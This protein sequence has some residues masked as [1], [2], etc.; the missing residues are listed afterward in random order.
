MTTENN[1]MAS[2]NI[3]V[4]ILTAR[5]REQLQE[6]LTSLERQTRK[7]F[8]IVLVD[9]AP[10]GDTDEIVRQSPLQINHIKNPKPGSYAESRNL[11][12]REAKGEFVA[13]LDDDCSAD[14]AWLEHLL[15]PAESADAVG[16]MV[17]P[18]RELPFPSWWNGELNWLLGLSVPG[19]IGNQ[20]G[21]AHY[22]QTANMLVR[23]DVLLVEKFQEIGGGFDQRKSLQYTGREDVELWRR[24][25][26][27][28]RR[29]LI[30][31]RAAVYHDIPPERLEPKAMQQRAFNDGL[32]FWRREK[33]MAYC[34][35]AIMD[36]A[37]FLPEL[38]AAIHRGKSLK[39]A[40]QSLL[41]WRARQAG[42]LYG[43]AR[44]GFAPL[45]YIQIT[46]KIL[47]KGARY[48]ADLL[49][50]PSRKIY[51]ALKKPAWERQRMPIKPERVLIAACGF[52]G[53]MALLA[54]VLD[55]LRRS[56]PDAKLTLLSHPNGKILF[57]ES[58]LVD[59][60]VV[61]PSMAQLGA[62]ESGRRLDALLRNK[63]FDAVIAPYYHNAP[64][65]PVFIGAGAPV[66]TFD[67]DVGLPRR[68]WYDMARRRIR[69]NFEAHE[70]LNLARLTR[71]VGLTEKPKPYR[72][73][74]PDKAQK[75]ADELLAKAGLE[76]VRLI[77][78]H[79]GGGY[80]EKMWL[81]K[82]WMRLASM[83]QKEF[84]VP[85]VFIGDKS[86]RP[87]L[88]NALRAQTAHAVN[89]CGKTGIWELA[90]IISRA[91][92]LATADSGPKH[93]AMALGTPTITLYGPTNE[94]RWG[95]F[96]DA[97]KHT[98]IRALPADLTPEELLGLPCDH[99][100][101]RISPER[102]MEALQ[103]M[104]GNKQS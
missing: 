27:A 98:A 97:D 88:E 38:A 33:K 67:S 91:E 45:R 86:A 15:E 5:R 73:A 94:R 62:K 28:G 18:L 85:P 60:T 36:I 93:L 74:I 44:A 17:L 40:W 42:F 47:F 59:D 43:Y 54:P 22:P 77:L 7:D 21:S 78:L 3:S 58:G 25:R 80:P 26:L 69:K 99:A 34:D 39:N 6:C 87:A 37:S 51:V 29:C 104:I 61:C 10:C 81:L 64:P 55:A 103:M 19:L 76:G 75:S 52:L 95:A 24:L 23:R 68:L 71:E 16:G 56:L 12:V 50:R 65:A 89:L 101:R 2:I 49:K 8:E 30:A 53:D 48:T 46:A 57:A 92:I 79:V 13:F 41:P 20:G 31:P 72:F 4:V 70:I 35:W 84:G 100:M 63:I 102:V 9:N 1:I 14:P 90:A 32:A 11:G 83:I 82:N 66:A 96:W